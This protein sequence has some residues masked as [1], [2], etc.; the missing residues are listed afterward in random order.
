MGLWQSKMLV[1]DPAG[2]LI[3]VARHDAAHEAFMSSLHGTLT[4]DGPITESDVAAYRAMYDACCRMCQ[5]D[6]VVHGVIADKRAITRMR[7]WIWLYATAE[8]GPRTA[9]YWPGGQYGHWAGWP[10]NTF[11]FDFALRVGGVGA[12]I[13]L[14]AVLLDIADKLM[15]LYETTARGG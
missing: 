15:D 11:A 4:C 3:E 2:N 10:D 14:H 8:F 12:G 9:G 1:A 6:P 5:A 13:R 7:Q